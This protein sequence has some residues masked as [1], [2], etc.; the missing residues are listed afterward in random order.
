[1]PL[2]AIEGVAGRTDP[3]TYGPAKDQPALDQPFVPPIGVIPHMGTADDQA[4]LQ[5]TSNYQTQVRQQLDSEEGGTPAR[6]SA[7]QHD[8]R[9]ARLGLPSQQPASGEPQQTAKPPQT[10]TPNPGAPVAKAISGQ[11][12]A[13]LAAFRRFVKQRE[14]WGRWTHD[15]EFR[16]VDPDTAAQLNAGAC[17]QVLK[18][19][20]VARE[21][22]QQLLGDFPADKV[23]WVLALHWTGPQVVP[24]DQVD[25]SNEDSWAASHDPKRVG[26]FAKK[27][28]AGKKVKPAILIDRPGHPQALVADGHHRAKAYRLEGRGVYAYVAHPRENLG[29]WDEL[30]ASQIHGHAA[31]AKAGD[32]EPDPV[33]AHAAG[34]AV[35][36]ADSG[37]VLMLQRGLDESDPA[38]GTWEFPGGRLEVGES[39]AQAAVR[40]WAE[41]TGCVLPAG[42]LAGAWSTPDGVY[43][44][45]VW[46]VASEADVPIDGTRDQVTNP[47]DPDGDQ[48]E[49]LAWWDPAQLHGNPAVRP[50]LLAT[51]PQVLAALGHAQPAQAPV[52]KAA[53]LTK[54]QAR[55][56]DPSDEPGKH[57]GNCSMFRLRAPDFETGACTLVQGG[58]DP[59]AVCDH[60]DPADSVTK[61]AG[62][63]KEPARRDDTWPGWAL[64][65]AAAAYWA[66]QLASDLLAAFDAA[67][68][69]EAYLAA[70]QEAVGS[71]EKA[72]RHLIEAALALLAAQGVAAA[73]IRA[74]T[75]RMSALYTDAY[76]IG[77]TSGQAVLDAAAAGE[78]VSRAVAEVGDWQPGRS[79]IARQLLGEMG[80]GSGLEALLADAGVHI[81]S[82]A[83]SRLGDL[84]R[85]LADG[86]L[87]GEN[88][89]AL[90]EE[91]RALLSNPSRARLVTITEITRASTAA[92]MRAYKRAGVHST[93]QVTVGDARVC[94]ICDENAAAG[95]V[96]IG[97]PYPSGDLHCPV[98]AGDRCANIPA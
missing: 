14:D 60:W 82:I 4:S 17:A 57:C 24:L 65:L 31:V 87:R 12:A 76:L 32:V 10:S 47:D 34:I 40:E 3:E 22:Y 45:F 62:D 38:A 37:R 51:L 20:A 23:R 26:K 93:R 36:A 13:E 46:Q 67:A 1:M 70:H 86:L 43:Q 6:E 58:I 88:A 69:V 95:P 29:P 50:E 59:G 55:Y 18:A 64:D 53:T 5:A 11:E 25:F 83:D 66:P 16:H 21:V 73:L 81:T 92:A 97:T 19:D 42:Q 30:H 8:Q 91:V 35:R 63:P 74:L 56:R 90:T 85:V 78:P 2:L 71:D 15:F 54:A 80:D 33:G 96:P 9:G 39:P 94:V 27:I 98:H 79:D 72:K 77:A 52:E 61:A 49:A 44:G 28:R 41:E 7:A 84:A 75:P 89:E 68:L 48:F